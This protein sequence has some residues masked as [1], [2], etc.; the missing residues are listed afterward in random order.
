MKKSPYS[1]EQIIGILKEHE[2]GLK[3]ADVCQKHGI[4][5]ATFYLWKAKFGGM[6]V[7]EAKRLRHLEQEN[8]KLKRLVADLTLDNV[9]LKELASRN[10]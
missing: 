7:N 1:E 6:D 10:W 3:T 2:A 9:A 8:S 5:P 4:S